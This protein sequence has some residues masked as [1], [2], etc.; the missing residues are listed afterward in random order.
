MACG[1][2]ACYGCVVEID[3]ALQAALRRGPGAADARERPD[4]ER[5][6]LPRRAH[7]ARVARSL[8]AVRHE[9]GHAQPREGNPPVAD[10]R[11]RRTGC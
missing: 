2:G 5:L 1:Y 7:R 8:D 4:P 11:D 6:G 9:D 10:R 3:G